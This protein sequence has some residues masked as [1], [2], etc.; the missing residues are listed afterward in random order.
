VYYIL[1][2]RTNKKYG[3]RDNNPEI[4]EARS[5]GQKTEINV[6][7]IAIPASFDIIGSSLMFIALTMIAASIYQMMRGVLVFIIAIMSVCFLRRIL[8]RHHWSSLGVILLGLILVG[9]SPLIYPDNSEGGED[10]SSAVQIIVGIGLVI[11]AQLFSGGHFIT[12]EKLFHNYYLHPLK[13]VGWE[14]FWGVI[15][16]I[17]ILII[18]QFIHC[19]SENIC[20]HGTIEDTPQALR[21]WAQNSLLWITTIFYIISVACF[22][23]LGVSITKY[24]SAAQRSTIDMSRTALIWIF[25]LAYQG[26]GHERFIWLELVGFILLIF[27]TLVYNEILVLPWFGFNR[28]TKAAL[29]TNMKSD[30]AL[31]PIL[32]TDIDIQSHHEEENF[33]K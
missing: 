5:K 28:F 11:V 12:E 31:K 10:T 1:Q 15:I 4:I 21:E 30:E 20:P 6:F 19:N 22:N 14:G 26:H 7:L 32:E 17:C 24:A 13:V 8:Y 2:W 27:G 33:G 23:C 29:K 18:L 3:G 25:F 9:A 16:Y